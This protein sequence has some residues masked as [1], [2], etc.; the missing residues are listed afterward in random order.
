MITMDDLRFFGIQSAIADSFFVPS[1]R[2]GI[3]D[4]YDADADDYDGDKNEDE[5]G[6]ENA[7][8]MAAPNNEYMFRSHGYPSPWRRP[9]LRILQRE[10]DGLRHRRVLGTACRDQQR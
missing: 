9:I 6:E 1:F 5:W 4:N 8:E 10:C 2:H 7:A 3:H